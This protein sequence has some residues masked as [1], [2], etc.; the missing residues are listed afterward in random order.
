MWSIIAKLAFKALIAA[1]SN[2]PPQQWAEF[3]A[4]VVEWLQTIQDKLPTGHPLR[5]VVATPKVGAAALDLKL[6]E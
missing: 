1:V 3:G 4:Q 5:T 6:P 2:V